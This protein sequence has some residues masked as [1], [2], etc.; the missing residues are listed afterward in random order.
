MKLQGTKRQGM[1][2]L[3]GFSMAVAAAAQ[4]VVVETATA[5]FAV[6]PLSARGDLSRQA[7]AARRAI[8]GKVY[9]YRA[10]VTGTPDPAPLAKALGAAPVTVIRVQGLPLA[11]AL[12][13]L[14]AVTARGKNPGGL[15]FL[16]GQPATNA[17]QSFAQL[18]TV[19]R[20][21]ALEPSD[22]L[23]LTCYSTAPENASA[24]LSLAARRYP[25]AARNLV[26]IPAP[27][28]RT[29]IECEA[30]A[31]ARRPAGYLNPESLAKSANYTQAVGIDT[32]KLMW[33][34]LREVGECSAGAVR[35]A[36][37][38]LAG[39]LD[40]RGGSIRQVA[41]SHLYPYSK[42]ASDLLRAIRFDFYDRAR[43][44]ASTM[45]VFPPGPGP[46]AAIETVQPVR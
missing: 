46:C 21:A 6:A 40:A 3:A 8:R 25:A 9:R 19:L 36:F 2:L 29:L 14:E 42:D 13:S 22:L 43:P 41:M 12:I 28:G 33:S 32:P 27:E 20:A 5:G 10:F 30:V 18:D 34:G 44:P 24:T 15:L 45:L 16:S 1:K 4:G 17:D 38:A 31:R 23:Q 39:T 35:A 37:T 11:G 26:Q 7:T